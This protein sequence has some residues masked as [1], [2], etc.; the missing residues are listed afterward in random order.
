ME[1]ESYYEAALDFIKESAED[2]KG[3]MQLNKAKLEKLDDVCT[4]VENLLKTID[5]KTAVDMS[6]NETIGTFAIE[7]ICDE[8]ISRTGTDREFFELIGVTDS[9]KFSKVDDDSIR[10]SF[11]IDNMWK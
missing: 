11:N 1:Y 4:A 6:V 5:C 7:I 10:I 2:F 8:I 9:F 3:R